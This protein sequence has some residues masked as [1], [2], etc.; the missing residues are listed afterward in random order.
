M[1]QQADAPLGLVHFFLPDLRFERAPMHRVDGAGRSGRW[2]RLPF[3]QTEAALEAAQVSLDLA[4]A[5]L[6]RR[7]AR[8]TGKSQ[9]SQPASKRVDPASV[10]AMARLLRPRLHCGWT[11]AARLPALPGPGALHLACLE[12][13]DTR[14]P[15]VVGWEFGSWSALVRST[16]RALLLLDPLW[17]EPWGTAH[18]ARLD[19]PA[20]PSRL[21]P[22]SRPSVAYRGLDGQVEKVQLAG[23]LMLSREPDDGPNQPET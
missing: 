13:R 8:P 10:M 15:L 21:P 17:P 6:L 2:R 22:D 3:R 16:P 19:L 1:L 5:L 9:R 12:G 11:D 23:F 7:T 4:L 20:R 18:N 14:W